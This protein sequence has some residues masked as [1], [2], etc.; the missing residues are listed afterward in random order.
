G[1]RA[2]HPRGPLPAGPIPIGRGVLPAWVH[3]RSPGG[4]RHQASAA[5]R[6]HAPPRPPLP[7]GARPDPP[8]SGAG[9]IEGRTWVDTPS[10]CD[11]RRAMRAR[12]HVGGYRDGS[13]Q[14]RSEQNNKRGIGGGARRRSRRIN[15][16]SDGNA[17][18]VTDSSTGGSADNALAGTEA[19]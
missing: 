6:W 11:S 12:R 10:I 5:V 17:T 14:I 13:D 16:R 2:A 4:W 1:D 18:A 9:R 8:P 15:A 7:T 3:A 19:V